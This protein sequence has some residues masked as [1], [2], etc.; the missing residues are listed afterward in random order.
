MKRASL[1]TEAIAWMLAKRG[2]TQSIAANKFGISQGAISSTKARED[3]AILLCE[4]MP[5]VAEKALHILKEDP[6]RTARSVAYKLNLPDAEARKIVLGLHAKAARSGA[7]FRESEGC[8][9]DVPDGMEEGARFGHDAGR[10][11]GRA[12]MREEAALIA[13]AI[14]GEHGVYVAAAIRGLA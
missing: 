5:E 10:R 6:T 2:R 12:D 7:V 4:R 3:S 1:S 9:S 14:G 13:E 11:E 8:M